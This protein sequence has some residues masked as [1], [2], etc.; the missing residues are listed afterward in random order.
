MTQS[1]IKQKINAFFLLAVFTVETFYPTVSYAL[2]SGPTTPDM[3]AFEPASTSNMV[4]LFSG[5]FS[6]NIPLL[7]VGGYPVN[8]SYHSGAGPEEEASWVG[9]GWSL[10]P[11][12]I[13]RQL[14]GVPDDFKGDQIVQ[15]DNKKPNITVGGNVN[16][17]IKLFG[18]RLPKLK[19]KASGD[20]KVKIGI[21]HNNYTG[22]K[23]MI[24]IGTS[25]NTSDDNSD[26]NTQGLGPATS[27]NLG[28]SLGLNVDNQSGVNPYANFQVNFKVNTKKERTA[29][30]D[31][32]E[33]QKQFGNLVKSLANTQSKS[34]VNDLKESSTKIANMSRILNRAQDVGSA[35]STSSAISFNSF[36]PPAMVQTPMIS[37]NFTA[38]LGLGIT[39]FGG[40]VV[41][42]IEGTYSKQE[43]KD[44]VNTAPAYGF[45]NSSD[46]RA[47]EEAVLDYNME[48]ESPYFK[49]LP[50][51]GVTVFTPDVYSVTSNAGSMQFRPFL[52]GA[53]IFFQPHKH[54]VDKSV[55]IGLEP[56]F[57][58]LFHLGIPLQLNKTNNISGKWTSRN[59]Y[60]DLGD[61]KSTSSSSPE[62]PSFY[63]KRIGEKNKQDMSFFN[64]VGNTSPVAV[65]LSNGFSAWAFGN[66]KAEGRMRKKG[67]ADIT[68]SFSRTV[69]DKANH[70]IAYLTASEASMYALQPQIPN[71]R[72]NTLPT[73]PN[74]IKNYISRTGGYRQ[75]HHISQYIITQDDG[76][77]MVYGTPVYNVS[78]QEVSFAIRPDATQMQNGVAIYS[79]SDN[80]SGNQNGKDNYFHRSA[81]PAYTTGHLLT[82]I[83]SPDYVDLTGN[84]ITDDD[85][86]TAVKLNYSELSDAGG[87]AKLYTWRTPYTNQNGNV[88]TAN[89]NSGY[90]S[91]TDDDKGNYTWGQKEM[92]TL[93]S[94][95]SKTMVA[96]FITEDREDGVGVLGENGGKD[97]NTRMKRLKE[98]RLYSKSDLY[99]NGANAIPIKVVHLEYDDTYPI[100]NN[101]PNNINGRGKLT[102]K[103]IWFSY[104]NNLKGQYHSYNFKYNIPVSQ[105]YE[106][107]QS[108]RWGTYKPKTAN[109][110]GL[111]NQDFP[112]STQ[113]KA[114]ADNFASYWQMNQI[115]LPSGAII[116][117]QYESD[118]Y[119]YVQDRKAAQMCFITGIGANGF[120]SGF[121]TSDKIYA[122]LPVALPLGTSKAVIRK[123]YFDGMKSLAYKAYVDL[124]GKGHWEYVSGYADIADVNLVGAGDVVE[125]IVGKING[126]N[127]IAKA[128]W[129]KLKLDLPRW[130][131]P[132][133]D[134]LN[135]ENSGFVSA[136]RALGAAF[137]RFKDLVESFD[138]RASR[139]GFGNHIDLAKSWVRLSNPAG[140]NASLVGKLGGG[141]RVK[142]IRITDEWSTMSG[143]ATAENGSFG[144][145]YDYTTVVAGPSGNET[146]SSG[147]ASYE[148]VMGGDEN[149]FREP[150]NYTDKH[151]FGMPK[152]FYLERPMGE[153]YFPGASVGYSKVTV[154]NLGADGSV[155]QNGSTV[156]EFYTAKDFPVKVDELPIERRQPKISFLPR[157]FG[158]KITSAVTVSQ[159]YVIE[160]NDMH[161]KPKSEAVY[162]R[163]G[164]EISSSKFFYKVNNPAA[165]KQDLNN[166]VSVV[167]KTGIIEPNTTVGMDI[168][169]FTEMNESMMENMGVAVDP[170]FGVAMYGI[171]PKFSFRLPLPKPN[172]EK[173]LYRGSTTVKLVNRY[174]IMEKMV[175]TVNGST[176]TT[177]NLLWDAETGEVLLTRSNNE[178]EENIYTFNYPAHWVYDGM[179]SSFKNEGVYISGFS[180]DATGKIPAAYNYLLVSGDELV[181]IGSSNQY[182]VTK[183][184]D[185]LPDLYLVDKDG[186]VK[187]S[188]SGANIKIMR[189][190]R[191]NMAIASVGSI[192]SV[193]NPIVGNTLNF[194]QSLN[195]LQAK[196]VEYNDDWK[197]PMPE[198]CAPNTCWGLNGNSNTATATSGTITPYASSTL[199]SN[200]GI[201][202]TRIYNAGY[203]N[204]G[205][206]AS[207]ISLNTAYWANLTFTCGAG[208]VNRAGVW[209]R[210]NILSK[211][212]PVAGPDSVRNISSANKGAQVN[213]LPCDSV[214]GTY[215]TW[216][217]HTFNYTTAVPKTLY[218]G[219]A[220]DNA[221]RIKL[222]GTVIVQRTVSSQDNFRYWS[223]YPVC[224]NAGTYTFE[225]QGM[226]YTGGGGNGVIGAEVYD[227]TIA[228]IQGATSDNNLN[229]LFSTRNL[230]GQNVESGDALGWAVPAGF[231]LL[232][233]GLNQYTGR[234][235]NT[236]AP[237]G[238]GSSLLTSYF[239]PYRTGVKGNWR[240]KREFL[241]D[242]K[243]VNNK[244]NSTDPSGTDIRRSGHFQTFVP[245][246]TQSGGNWNATTDNKWQWSS[247]TTK[248]NRKGLEIE[249]VDALNRY[250]AA[251]H[252][253]L[254]ST[255]VAVTSNSFFRESGFDGFEDY[256]FNLGLPAPPDTCG[257]IQEHFNF[258]KSLGAGASLDNTRSHS[259]NFSLKLNGTATIEK[260]TL[261]DEPAA[262]YDID[263]ANKQYR[264]T[265]GY[266]R[267]GFMPVPS[268]KYIL[269]G[270]IYD[271]QPKSASINGLT[272][273]ISGTTY[274]VNDNIANPSVYS[275]VHV[276]EG[277]KRFE[278]VFTMPASGNFKL[279][280]AGSNIYV[281]DIRIHPYDAQMKSFVYDASSMRLMAELDENNFATFYEYDDEGILIR[282]K[283]ETEKG[284]STIKETRSSIRKKQP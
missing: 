224:L 7:D 163:S 222:N 241:Y 88:N 19:K 199:Y 139:K 200:Y 258:R 230:V 261:Q 247:M 40:T 92:W 31:L 96:Q 263:P 281:D 183:P 94:I 188:V 5:D 43:L 236:V 242:T 56:G 132:E 254:E 151:L 54:D 77:R 248:L 185:N 22:Y 44:H 49:R 2:T 112:Y 21:S 226:N 83:L 264:I 211:S 103:R 79:G 23:G 259:G 262:I 207:F 81:T 240:T 260:P 117:V 27:T 265:D 208:P 138:K 249:N 205:N 202:G 210:A 67:A 147:V 165:E 176:N 60:M 215:S 15:E 170:S 58:N 144:Q 11:G 29:E 206:A 64:A 159:G 142:E 234:Q 18:F 38:S 160:N 1:K 158:A 155:G 70:S 153:A 245:Y 52:K 133:Y 114:D 100:L 71:Y 75:Q 157:L 90:K 12:A 89:Y 140:I 98:I 82:S 219:I 16:V 119:A 213:A 51:L 104:G 146:I 148:P 178:F 282:L 109:P 179:G 102:L 59:D 42:G 34:E 280:L 275:K 201:Y 277:W 276:V 172:Y 68:S 218:V 65:R 232:R 238:G 182:W 272:L 274:N 8:L 195:V 25:F 162:G 135:S 121:A 57:G 216:L 156:S 118:D 66:G 217:G 145:R 17:S 203:D 237:G 3:S 6:Y 187:T 191:R 266:M 268:K 37:K 267:N 255:P 101:V 113:N 50:N 269:S 32:A 192:V 251:L 193:N 212:T 214:I 107:Y 173:R 284:I 62:N 39:L 87:N 196:A 169:M 239:N 9:F 253:Y 233:T 93:H 125:I 244:V 229:I 197:I 186:I 167:S 106:D 221:F 161:G 122:K 120:S 105:N 243:R 124:D 190:G 36:Q 256:N 53:G 220:G 47:K 181:T 189:S 63:F 128:S 85:L 231:Y 223:I 46:A 166:D 257:A 250:S 78:Q 4:D 28:G 55:D 108:D 164:N 97:G 168:D 235:I 115:E 30:R 129:Q 270:W 130:A 143:V 33:A 10:N 225:F 246:W 69:R 134:N 278:V 84:G 14:R 123:R 76:Q 184:Y 209:P 73:A 154:R 171:I 86:G 175:K 26:A 126:Y 74:A 194:S 283:K 24:G 273:S 141:H 149:P 35:L 80:T 45:M 95:V 72:E 116:N 279:D 227:N 252:G 204:T 111:D 152:Y 136:I 110:N 137:G 150:I 20:M 174:G 61:F 99:A 48:K 180:T 91:I 131:Y 127:P 271:G 198:R 13:N 228:Q 177:Q 41:P